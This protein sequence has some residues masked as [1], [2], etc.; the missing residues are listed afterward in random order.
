M[1]STFY[2]FLLIVFSFLFLVVLVSK[3]ESFGL[4][5]SIDFFVFH[6]FV[7]RLESGF[8][9]NS[10]SNFKMVLIWFGYRGF[11]FLSHAIRLWFVTLV[12][13]VD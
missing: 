4:G 5:L 1:C 13:C 6:S 2:S 11:S 12:S 9:K 7:V 10:L 8:Q 3:I